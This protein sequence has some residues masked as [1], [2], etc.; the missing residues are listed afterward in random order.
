MY[1]AADLLLP[2]SQAEARQLTRYFAIP[3]RKIQVVPNG[4][5]ERFARPAAGLFAGLAS[6][7]GYILYAGRIEPRKN[8]LGFLRAMRGAGTPIVFLGDVVPGHEDYLQRCRRLAGSSARFVGRLEHDD[9]R[10]VSAYHECGCLALTSW[11]ETPGLVALEAAMS[12]A[13]LVLTDRGCAAEYFGPHAR[14]VSPR[15]PR[16]VR[17]ATLAALRQPRNRELARL[18]QQNFSWRATAI[19]TLAGYE[20]LSRTRA[21]ME[22]THDTR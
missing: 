12:G 19:A 20:R 9:P 2:N 16:G 21:G 1:Q 17:Q 13:P 5:D 22:S 18:T 14:Y 3:S 4:A 7:P 11:F 6:E 8:Q 15:D 10:L